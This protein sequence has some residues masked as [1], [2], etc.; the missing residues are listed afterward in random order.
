MGPHVFLKKWTKHRFLF[1]FRPPVS[2]GN[3]SILTPHWPFNLTPLKTS[4]F[5]HF[6]WINFDPLFWPV[7]ESI[8]GSILGRFLSIFF[9]CFLFNFLLILESIL[10][11]FLKF[12][13]IFY[14]F[15]C[16]YKFFLNFIN[17]FRI[18]FFLIENFF[19]RSIFYFY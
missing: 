5:D 8:L 3:W 11:L 15:L 12:F 16:F 10:Q 19:M 14:F 7:F 13:C 17:F 18:L 1:D 6:F 2:I 9:H 4:I